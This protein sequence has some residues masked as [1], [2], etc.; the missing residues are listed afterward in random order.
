MMFMQHIKHAWRLVLESLVRHSARHAGAVAVVSLLISIALGWY[1]VTHF[2]FN[3]DTGDMLDPDL[4]FRVLDRELDEAFP[5]LTE[6]L[7][8]VVEAKSPALAEAA[9]GQLTE[10]LRGRPELFKSVYQPG[11]GAFWDRNALLYLDTDELWDLEENLARAQPFLGTLAQYPSVRGLFGMLQQAFDENELSDSQQE[12]LTKM[13]IQISDV[14][15]AQ[16]TGREKHISWRDAWLEEARPEEAPQRQFIIAQPRLDFSGLEPARRA[17]T[18]LRDRIAQTKQNY[19]SVQTR[20]T[21]SVAMAEEEMQNLAAD[22]PIVSALSFSL[23]CLLLFLALRSILTVAAVLLTLAFGLMVTTAFA[24]FAFGQL[25]LISVTFAVLFIG[26]GVDFGIQFVMRFREEQGRIG[27]DI[28]TALETTARSTGAALTLAAA[29][30]A[31]AF[32]SFTPASYRGL[33]EL[34]AIAGSGMIVALFAN[35]TLLPALLKLFRISVRPDD[36][37]INPF[38]TSAGDL[39][40]NYRRPILAVA[41]LTLVGAVLLAPSLRF[42]FNP[43]NL[44]DPT[45]ESVITFKDLLQDPDVSPYLIE[46]LL[47]DLETA[48]SRAAELKRL[49]LVK[50]AVTAASFVPGNQEEK[51]GIIGNM[52]LSL[53]PL[54][55]ESSDDTL[56]PPTTAEAQSTVEDVLKQLKDPS[57]P[58]SYSFKLATAMRRLSDALDRLMATPGWPDRA[59]AELG[60]R[61][62][63]DFPTVLEKLDKLLQ[64]KKFDIE[65]LPGDLRSR[66]LAPDGRARIEVYPAEVL[67]NNHAL[68]RFVHEVQK[69]EPRTARSAV[70]IVAGGDTVIES[71]LQATLL[72]LMATTV[73]MILLIRNLRGVLLV[74]LPLLAA[75]LFTLGSSVLFDLPLNYANIIALP[76][77]IG[78]ANAFGIYLVLRHRHSN[79][80]TLLRSSTPP[81]ILFSGLT[82]MASF[83]S[84]AIARHPGM[85]YM[86]VLVTLALIFALLSSLILLP[87]VMAEWQGHRRWR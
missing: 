29:A 34:G 54:L 59:L 78:L 81:A 27:T 2:A 37:G 82:T 4:P 84:L 74:L 53:G 83:G 28:H 15:E 8:V 9:A 10:A 46:V 48:R 40:L 19:P 55:Q 66:Y 26:M 61:L 35:L 20:I 57:G 71:S 44:R 41:A 12:S 17:L 50:K 56:P 77:L 69:V 51:L 22:G 79:I 60:P 42:D 49:P 45:T 64:A 1:T 39:L 80:A 87:A 68:R 38:A 16:A 31:I 65:D 6:T 52:E 47:P 30:A 85:S 73:F 36:Q 21:G 13:L 63:G 62:I 25:N 86:G 5:Q 67:S 7:V 43:L 70:G 76:L 23:V 24:L 18:Y 14:V 72:A 58:A 32:F 75:L 11:S 33:A 3:T